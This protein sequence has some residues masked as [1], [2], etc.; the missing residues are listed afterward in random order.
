M[1]TLTERCRALITYLLNQ[2]DKVTIA[3]IA[4][5]FNV[6]SR[7]IRYD[8][9]IIDYWLNENDIKLMR[10]SRVGVW[11]KGIEEAKEKL[12]DIY[13]KKDYYRE[14]VFTP[15]ERKN[16]ILNLLFQNNEP[17][18]T[19]EIANKLAV[20]RSTIFKDLIIVEKWLNKRDINIDKI[21][22]KGIKLR[23]T[24]ESF[25]KGFLDYIE[26]NFDKSKILD[27]VRQSQSY[28]NISKTGFI[29]DHQI[30]DVFSKFNLTDVEKIIYLLEKDLKI[31]FADTAF[32]GLLIHISIAIERLKRKEKIEMPE[33]Q[34]NNLRKTREFKEIRKIFR[35]I[36]DK[37]LIEI[38]DT[39]IGYITIHVLGAKLRDNFINE[40]I[41]A[42]FQDNERVKTKLDE[43]IE[44]VGNKLQYD[45]KKDHKLK[46]GLFIHIKPAIVRLKYS[47]KNNNP[48]LDDIT[49]N[50]PHI[51]SVCKKEISIF[52]K[53][54]NIKF[55]E[56]EIA[57]MAIHIGSAIERLKQPS[58]NED[59]KI[60]I[61]CSSGIGTA[62]MLSS[63]LQ[64]EFP[65]IK[66]VGQYSVF[67]I[68]NKDKLEA[69]FI[70]SSVSLKEKLSKP[71][72]NVN[73]LLTTQDIVKLRKFFN[74]YENSVNEI[75]TEELIDI[76]SKHCD[77]K[78]IYALNEEM[79]NYF[80]RKSN[81]V[82]KKEF[83]LFDY[84]NEETIICNIEANNF[85]Q[86]LTKTAYP[87]LEKKLINTSYINKMIK[88][89]KILPEHFCLT[90]EF[91]MPHAESDN[92]VRQTCMSL[93][94]LNN[95]V[96][97]NGK[98]IRCI[99]VLAAVDRKSHEKALENLIELL[100]NKEFMLKLVNCKSSIEVLHLI[101]TTLN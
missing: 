88:I 5:Y 67:E 51:Y 80:Y 100:E 2:T 3:E 84:L 53:E 31:K 91:A 1:I 65:N 83:K 47:L 50:Y 13:Q 46:R 6:S 8:L 10:K 12:K 66:I 72:I 35:V 25:R 44:N 39:E 74:L 48:L 42:E 94:I 69:D 77:V 82:N 63:R 41:V 20:S 15:E 97:L 43:F 33:E 61:V 56:D 24:E 32:V 59:I 76:I 49:K 62:N 64:K 55:N 92:D 4:N 87:L 14:Y 19:E 54:F 40:D 21:P 78:N 85:I 60:M 11:I 95:S 27:F 71:V 29:M 17:I 96:E 22:N 52:E 37:Y 9:D 23:A 70:V 26:S 57:Y 68:Y 38:P 93:G 28:E 98:F 81:L 79:N 45:L 90:E 99:L 58:S 101:K 16:N 86:A 89:S 18:T 36:E 7:T 30:K 75:N 34:L 73:P